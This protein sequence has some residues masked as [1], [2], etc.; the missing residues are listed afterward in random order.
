[1]LTIPNYR[2][3]QQLYS[4]S[5]SQ[6]YRAICAS[7]EQS[8]ILKL[9][10]SEYPTLN[11]LMQFRHQYNIAKNL[12][13]PGIIK[14]LSLEKYRN[15]YLLVLEDF[16]GI[17]L[18]DYM[19]VKNERE[20][21][22]FSNALNL[23]Q[24]LDIAIQIVRILEALHQ[25]G[26]IHKDIKPQNILI[27]PE[28]QEIKIIDFCN[29]SLLPKENPEIINPNVFEGTAAY[30]SPEQTG[31]MN[32]GIDYRTD[33][34]SLGVTFYELLTGQLPFE[35]NEAMELVHCHIARI[36][37]SPISINPAIGKVLNDIVLKLM[38]KTPEERYQTALGLR[39]DLEKCRKQLVEKGNITPFKLAQNDIGSRFIIPE[40]LYGRETEV[41]TLLAAFNRVS[42]RENVEIEPTHQCSTLAAYSTIQNPKSQ[43]ELML[44]AGF[45]GIGK[46]A[47]VNEVHKAIVRQRGY[48]IK[49]K[50][51]QFQRDIPFSAW[52]QALQNLMRQ[53]FAESFIQIETW[54]AKILTALGTQAKVLV[55]V[56]PELELLIGKPP[57]ISE[58]AGNVGQNRFYL[59]FHKFIQ[60]FATKE[61]PLVIFLDDLQWADTASLKLMELLMSETNTSY[62]LLIGAYRDNEVS[63]THPLML[64]LDELKKVNARVN[65]ISL[66]PLNKSSLNCLIS[67]TLNYSKKT[68]HPLTDVVCDRTKGNPYFATQLLKSLHE[69]ALIYFTCKKNKG[70]WQYNLNEIKAIYTSDNVVEFMAN[71]LQTLPVN[72]L[73]VLKIAACIGNSFDLNTLAI[74]SRR[75]PDEIATALLRALQEGLVISQSKNY[76]LKDDEILKLKS[77]NLQQI[78]YKFGHDRVQQAA[79]LLIPEAQKQ[80]THL[81]I[82]QLLLTHIP[83]EEREKRIFDI[84]NQ[85]NYG[86]ELLKNQTERDELA[87]LNLIAGR[88]ALASTA[89]T[90]ALKYF[91][92]GKKL[93]AADSWLH[94]YDL[95]LALY[96]SAAEAAYLTGNFAETS[97][98]VEIVLQQAKT[99]LDKMKVYE[100][101]IKNY[102]SQNKPLVAIKIALSALALLGINLPEQPSELDVRYRLEKMRANLTLQKI[103]ELIDLPEM[104]DIE[105]QSAM[106]IFSII[107]SSLFST[108]IELLSLV[109]F[110]QVNLSIQYGNS[111]ESAIAYIN[112]GLILCGR[113]GEIDSGYRFG[114]LAL[115]LLDKLKNQELKTKIIFYTNAWIKHWKEHL[116]E[117]LKNF[118]NAYTNGLETG[119]LQFAA[120]SAYLYC[121]TLFSMGKELSQVQR[122]IA[123]YGEVLTQMKQKATLEKLQ[124]YEYAVLKL[125]EVNEQD[126]NK[127]LILDRPIEINHKTASCQV[128]CSQLMLNYLFNNYVKALENAENAEKLLA[129]VTSTIVVP[130]FYF[131][132]SLVRLAIYCDRSKDEQK[133]LLKKVEANLEKMQA[134]AHHA[135]MNYLHKFDLV[136]AEQHRVLGENVQAMEYYDKAIAEAKEHEFL[137][138]EAL[139]NELAAK[140]YLAWGKEK[141]AKVYLTEAY[142][143]YFHWGALAK[144]KDLENRY[145]HLLERIEFDK[146][147]NSDANGKVNK[148]NT[149]N[150]ISN[151]RKA[152]EALDLAAV[153]TASQAMSKEINLESLLSTL[154]QVAIEN[155]GASKGALFLHERGD[156][157]LEAIALLEPGKQKQKIIVNLQPSVAIPAEGYTNPPKEIPASIINYV[158]RTQEILLLDDA[159]IET[160]FA[161]DVY[162]I[163]QQPKSVLCIPILNQAKLIGILYL[164]N[165]LTV[166]AFIPNRVEILK[167]LSSQAAISIENARIYNKLEQKVKERTAE[168][169]IAKQESEAANHAKS[170]FIANMS[171]EL[172]TPL[173]VIL[174]FSNLMRSNSN[175]SAE[176]QENLSII[177][178]NGEHLLN[179]IN[180]VLDL[181]KIESG[182]MTLNESNFDLYYLLADV[183][184]IFSFKAKKQGLQLLFEC[185]EN[186]PQYISTDQLKLRQVLINLLNNAIKFTQKGTVSFKVKLN[187]PLEILPAKYLQSQCQIIFEVADTG[188]GIAPHELEKLF[189]PFGQTSSSQQVQEGTGLGLAISR[190]F[191]NLMGGQITVISGGRAFT[192]DLEKLAIAS[193]EKFHN[194]KTSLS[195]F[196][197][198]FIFDI[199]PKVIDSAEVENKSLPIRVIGLAPNQ[200]KYRMLVVDDNEYNRQLLLKILGRLDFELREANNGQEAI[201]IWEAWEPHLIWMDMR[202]PVMDGYEATKHIKSTTKGQATAIIA[203]TASVLEEQKAV[204]LSTGCD[205]FVRKPFQEKVIFEI[206]AQH[207]EVR[208]IY[209]KETLPHQVLNLPAE[210]LN[211]NEF[212]TAM[213]KDWIVQLHKASLDA[214]SEL[215][216]QMIDEIPKIHT[217][218]I[219]I[220]RKWVNNFDFEKIL[221][222]VELFLDN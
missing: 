43:I 28:S 63:A 118:L 69:Q 58:S 128:Y 48:F 148:I 211:F 32:L 38:A 206:I 189:K 26:I 144:V 31:R 20:N 84:V 23:N 198:T 213:Q 112:Y 139:A 162:I 160:N 42:P 174:G 87:Q 137:N 132:D 116:K 53:L 119:D 4:G 133:N 123:N 200:P 166:K 82:G 207:L 98:L 141:I 47:V 60:V 30:M 157:T 153:M 113:L 107:T 49:G 210:P 91:H 217:S 16:G 8:V 173:N 55:D 216:H 66:T 178:S 64:T 89:Y 106:R 121:N 131:Y 1:M 3:I 209:E 188:V 101:K 11:Q 110:K 214:D 177:N 159:T 22:S 150:A 35:S 9:L 129:G 111:L 103:E 97:D 12:T 68:L 124:I 183:E 156:L 196:N 182:R 33:F 36:P 92:F 175:L 163:Q 40:K 39:V 5:R 24:F 184:N 138:E 212:L 94:L 145:P 197:T 25:N 7:N 56:I 17:S 18:S 199:R 77:Q 158:A 219:Q 194:E 6:V 193:Q 88:K 115:N 134:W 45:S 80:L 136:K 95:T 61:H 79:Y 208:Y 102:Q 220:L 140:F 90:A 105:K 46:T 151:S 81:E 191:I 72:T 168:L 37:I 109:V 192:P 57:D 130:I 122:E 127:K 29:S 96:E 125:T 155:A 65:K 75:S 76:F 143:T 181:S 172:R 52:V 85:L 21:F 164:E 59:L 14:H 135:P 149:A 86:W 179:L 117:T 218:T 142:Y 187:N 190:Q 205:N 146:Q 13:L 171:H 147:G 78:Y 195:I 41:A 104:T 169:E 27:N 71:Q 2:I 154:M 126:D 54:K 161:N 73:D 74:A 215:V 67:D 185:A 99:V 180:Q 44:V 176:E 10:C 51:D 108:N 152:S 167:L 120:L 165:N 83:Q 203:I 19:R 62:L 204:I 93:L 100:I 50:F 70:V 202:M 186:V 15:S 170:A 34:Y 201:K 221:D 222:R 114:Q